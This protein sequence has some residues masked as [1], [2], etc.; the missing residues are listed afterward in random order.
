MLSKTNDIYIYI[1]I[2]HIRNV[3]IPPTKIPQL[4]CEN[5]LQVSEVSETR[6]RALLK[7]QKP[8]HQQ[9]YGTFRGIATHGVHQQAIL[10]GAKKTMTLQ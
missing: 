3:L 6:E 10:R 8:C 9:C 7:E 1:N 2:L 5:F 4:G